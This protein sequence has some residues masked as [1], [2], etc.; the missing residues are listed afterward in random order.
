M[1]TARTKSSKMPPAGATIA[2]TMREKELNG[3]LN[4]FC[5]TRSIFIDLCHT[6]AAAEKNFDEACRTR[7][8]QPGD[9]SEE[10]RRRT[11]SNVREALESLSKL[12]EKLSKTHDEWA[13]QYRAIFTEAKTGD[14]LRR[15][16]TSFVSTSLLTN[17]LISLTHRVSQIRYRPG[18]SG[19][20]RTR[21]STKTR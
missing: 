10:D 19:L 15:L 1:S 20:E 11:E 6:T 21:A 2:R 17:G 16:P 14:L 4:H 7:C 5:K 9:Q 13:T 12:Q 18:C 8:S 3:Q